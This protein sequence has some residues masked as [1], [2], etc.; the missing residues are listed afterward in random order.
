M[1]G[2]LLEA[3]AA[4]RRALAL[5][6]NDP[7][8]RHALG[9]VLLSQ[10]RYREGWPLYDARHQIPELGLFKP[11]LSFP[12][13][14]GESL[15]GKHLLIFHEQGFGD[16]IMF[17]RFAPL[18]ADWGAEVTLFCNPLL[19]R[20]FE[21]LGVRVLGASGILEFPDPDFWVMSS[22]IVG[23][24]QLQPSDITG[25]PYLSAQP[26]RIG[27]ARIGIVGRGNPRHANDIN[28]SLP[29]D[30]TRR[31]L[32]LPGATSLHLE[33][34]TVSDWADTAQIVASL[35]LIVSVDTAVAHLAGALG[36]AVWLLIPSLMTDW[37]WG[38]EDEE[39]HW[40]RSAR[41]IRQRSGED[42]AS[43]IDRVEKRLV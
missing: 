23:R 8:T 15:K 11:H 19:K 22:S 13:W 7:K 29:D 27:G 20:L 35:D 31:L 28:R 40:Y 37:R 41:L 9:T 38:S 4:F 3:E 14:Q 17:S 25:S 18:L 32:S 2:R 33:D 6:P 16:Q 21:P 24:A 36:K 34:L 12:E 42:W 1:H 43:V 10:G 39:T 26:Q 5:A 30:L